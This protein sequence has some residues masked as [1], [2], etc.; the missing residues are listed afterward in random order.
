MS[1]IRFNKKKA[2]RAASLLTAGVMALS[3]GAMFTGCGD[4]AS[5]NTAVVS[6]E[7]AMKALAYKITDV[8]VDYN[9]Y[10]T[11]SY[12]NGYYYTQISDYRKEDDN[13][14][15]D[16]KIIVLDESGELIREIP[17][18]QQTDPDSYG[19]ING[20]IFV[21][22]NGNV[23][24]FVYSS[25]YTDDTYNETTE[26][27]TFDS[28][29][30][31]TKRVDAS[32][33]YH[34]DDD[35]YDSWFS[36]AIV[37]NDGNIILNLGSYIQ[38]CDS[39][40]NQL[41]KTDKLTGDNG[42]I[43]SIF[44]TNTGIPAISLYTWDE[45][46][47][48]NK[49]IEI[50]V[51]AKALGNEYAISRSNTLFNGSGDYIAYYSSD[52]GISGIRADNLQSETVI[53]LLNLGVDNSN[54]N[55][56]SVNQDGSFSVMANDYSS[57]EVRTTISKL[58]PIDASEVKERT[59]ITLGCYYLS[60]NIRSQVADFNRT[61]DDYVI[62]CT[63]YSENNDTS[64]YDAA[65]KNF[66]N[67]ILAGNVP[68]ILLIDSSMPYDSYAEKGLFADMYTLMEKDDEISKDDFYSNILEALE[69][70][71]KLYEITPAVDIMGYAGKTSVVGNEN[72]L[73][74]EKC[75]ELAAALGETTYI[76]GDNLTTEASSFI[77]NVIVYSDFIDYDK[78]TCSFDTPEFKA[79]LEYAKQFP[80]EIDY[81]SIYNDDYWIESEMAIRKNLALFQSVYLSEFSSYKQYRYGY[82]G[83]E[84]TMMAYPGSYLN[85]GSSG[86][87]FS[88][89][90][91]LAISSK[92][93]YKDGAWEFIK[94]IL[95]N[96]VDEETLYIYNEQLGEN[97]ATD[98]KV[99][100][101]DYYSFP[102]MKTQ[103]E[104]L[105]SSAMRKDYYIDADGNEQAYDYSYY[106]G[107]EEIKL[108]NLTEED[109][110]KVVDILSSTNRVYRYNSSVI[111]IVNE[112]TASFFNGTKSADE[113]AAMIQSRISLYL[114]EQY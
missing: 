16:S 69:S 13:Y 45:N 74:I 86:T 25:T 36:S 75:N 60:W 30:N 102:I 29:G 61:N 103:L 93:K 18:Y 83:E 12:V 58:E 54:V 81:E 26:F 37:D 20:S 108:E 21:D 48:E 33:L 2:G 68:D 53:N 34:I 88:P 40:G 107:N 7:D 64:D 62:F 17:V 113:T 112:E 22:D 78:G 66:N 3:A 96:T 92:S 87:M 23:S 51:A 44:L 39:E 42:W 50:D 28:N 59:A 101:T 63:T 110:D 76:L 52:T 99:Y 5:S 100:T 19:G 65:V 67:E 111:D 94:Y 41:F 98:E 71:G 10:N 8:T 82:I 70:D 47:S 95:N 106:I 31:E 38:V 114:S 73:S 14:Y 85:E 6:Q 57:S 56:F 105:R 109:L 46:G 1:L 27:V 4:S 97:I 77:N 79:A 24:C 35:D 11:V 80:V 72:T 55:S 9:I 104:K 15:Y 91:E 90:I 43:N 32:N 49:I 84:F 89:S